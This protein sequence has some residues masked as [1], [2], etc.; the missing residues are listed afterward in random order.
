MSTTMQ[1]RFQKVDPYNNS[2]FIASKNRDDEEAVYTKLSKFHEALVT[3]DV[4]TFLPIYSTSKYA[5]IRFKK[6]TKFTFEEGCIYAVEFTIR[7]SEYE[8]KK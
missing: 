5:T 3:S 8:N 6:N 1:L 4:T 7:K 2:I